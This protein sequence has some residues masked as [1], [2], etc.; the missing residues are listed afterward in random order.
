[1]LTTLTPLPPP[2]K[3]VYKEVVLRSPDKHR[4]IGVQ[5]ELEGFADSGLVCDCSDVGVFVFRVGSI[6]SLH[7]YIVGAVAVCVASYSD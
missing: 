3:D 1:M 6:R 5:V 2:I 7:L 4:S